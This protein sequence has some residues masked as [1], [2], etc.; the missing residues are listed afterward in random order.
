MINLRRITDTEVQ[1]AK[2]SLAATPNATEAIEYA[3]SRAWASRA[4]AAYE[5][6]V[7]RSCIRW[8][9]CASS[10]ANEAHEHASG[11][12][13]EWLACIMGELDAAKDYALKC[14]GA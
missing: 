13:P 11:V 7:E 6:A 5:L 9:L 1:A 3:T 12:S 2:A 14:L 8:L 10:F 4:L